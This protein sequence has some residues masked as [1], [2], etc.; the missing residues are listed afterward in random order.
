EALWLAAAWMFAVALTRRGVSRLRPVFFA[1]LAFA[2][3]TLHLFDHAL[4]DG[5]YVCLT[6]AFSAVLVLAASARC[7]MRRLLFGGALGVLTAWMAAS[8]TESVL[9]IPMVAIASAVCL[10][11]DLIL[12]RTSR[13]KAA[14]TALLF[15]GISISVT[16]LPT[17]V[18]KGIGYL[19]HGVCAVNTAQMRSHLTLL[20]TLAEIRTSGA[21]PRFVPITRE[22]RALAYS[23]SPTLA[24]LSPSLEDSTSPFKTAS[25]RAGLPDGEIG[26]GWI[27]HAFSVAAGRIGISSLDRFDSFCRQAVRELNEGFECGALER[28]WVPHCLLGGDIHSWGPYLR[29]GMVHS[30]SCVASPQMPPRDN[31]YMADDFDQACLRRA[32]LVQRDVFSLQG[33]VFSADVQTPVTDIRVVPSEGDARRIVVSESVRINRPDVQTAFQKQGLTVPLAC[34]FRVKGAILSPIRTVK[35]PTLVFCS[36]DVELGR[37]TTYQPGRVRALHPDGSHATIYVGQ[38]EAVIEAPLSE[39]GWRGEVSPRLLALGHSSTAWWTA[40]G[41]SAV[42]LLTSVWRGRR[43]RNRRALALALLAACFYAMAILRILFYGVLSSGA[44]L[45][46]PRY[47]QSATVLV[48]AAVLTTIAGV[49]APAPSVEGD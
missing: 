30:L 33:W 3:A 15:L 23:V 34:G 17:G 32:A 45:A 8:R 20:K 24:Q 42:C 29:D 39:T 11:S 5:F 10:F 21:N 47:L 48:M 41:L 40:L 35:P 27:W 18:I 6:L 44:W 4:T 9:I 22:A 31:D 46:E 37:L 2:P 14:A 1:V 16:M 13:R 26:A 43:G 38:D 49:F 25:R 28:R 36:K 12:R 7:G 19:T